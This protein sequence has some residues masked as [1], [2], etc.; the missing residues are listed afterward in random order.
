MTE[1][2]ANEWCGGCAAFLPRKSFTVSA[3]ARRKH[4]CKACT[5]LKNSLYRKTHWAVYF[6]AER[7]RAARRRGLPCPGI[8][9]ADVVRAIELLAARGDSAP[10]ERED[11]VINVI[12]T[13]L[14]R[15]RHTHAPIQSL[16]TAP[17]GPAI[18]AAL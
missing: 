10:A 12:Q 13:A 8:T 1:R 2:P 6:A 9:A 5:S 11:P 4:R 17:T 15:R 18:A 14:G 3:I 16:V 7:R